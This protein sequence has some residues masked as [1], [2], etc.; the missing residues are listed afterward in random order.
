MLH[1]FDK[2]SRFLQSSFVALFVVM[3]TQTSFAQS[4]SPKTPDTRMD[5]FRETIHGTEIIDPYRWLENQEAPETRQWIDEQNKYTHALLDSLPSRP[6]LEKRLTE[7]MRVDSIGVPF[8]RGG[9]YF[10]FTKKAQ[11]DLSKLMLR[12]GLNGPEEVLI[13]PHTLSPDHTTSIG[14]EDLS[15]DGKLMLYSIRRG[16]EDE[17]ELRVM[18]VDRRSDLPDRLPRALYRGVSFK[19]DGSGFYYNLQR[20]DVGLRVF[21]HALGTD[22]S[23]DVEVFG[24]GYGPDKWIGASVSDDD[25][26]V[27][28]TVQ[29]GWA[30]NEVYVQRLPDGP[31]KPIVNDVDAHFYAGFAG[32][33]LIMQ[34]DWQAPNGRMLSVDPEDPAREKW[35]EIVPPSGDSIQGFTLAGGRFFVNY[36]HNVVSTLKSFSID[37]KPLGEIALPGLGSVSGLV[38]RWGSNEAFFVYRSFVTPATTYRYQV[39]TGSTE[40]WS[41]P[42]VP[43]KS[44]DFEVQQVWYPSKDGTKIPMFLVHKKGLQRNGKLPVLLYGYGGFNVSQT[45]RFST[46]AAVWVEHGGVYALAN[47]RGGGE[48]GESW[49]KAGMLDKKQNVFDDFIAAAEW[50]IANKYTNS[51]KLAIQGGSNGGL[52]VGAALT[53]RPELYAAVLCEFPDLDMIGYY[54][55]KNN[56]PPAL[57]EYGNASDPAQFKFLHAYS[58]YQK[59]KPGTRYPA[60]FLTTGDADTRVPPPQARKM[61]ARLQAATASGKPVLLLYDNKAGHAGGTPLGKL[62]DDLS[63]K[64]SFLFWQLQMN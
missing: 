8:E 35:R 61:T 3:C 27:L 54:R 39:S 57:L 64:M 23:R 44:D 28:F 24:K 26:Y 58:P 7:L 43:F 25:R 29:H 30:R 32:N 51:S 60:V 41:K 55:F 40:V 4:K 56:N 53:Q 33:Q 18:D 42:T 50:L 46:T 11:D 31:I 5:N 48:F 22:T 13:D 17:T 14:L 59:V 62:I 16:G 45:P 21:Y 6:I 1:I 36:L 19:N 20:R 12:K 49:H 52:L 15:G 9:R 10:L 38:G 37:G 34:T 47:I 2:K 63:L